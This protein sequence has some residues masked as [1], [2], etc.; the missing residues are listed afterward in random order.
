MGC[1]RLVEWLA[2]NPEAA[3]RVNARKPARCWPS[4]GSA[5]PHRLVRDLFDVVHQ[6]VQLPLR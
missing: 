5:R 2:L 3:L 4:P 1:A 6:A